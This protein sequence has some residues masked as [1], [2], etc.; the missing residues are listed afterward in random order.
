MNHLV[1]LLMIL[2]IASPAISG[3]LYIWTDANGRKQITDTPPVD[4]KGKV[5]KDSFRRDDP[6]EIEAWQRKNDAAIDAKIQEQERIQEQNAAKNKQALDA[7]VER[8]KAY[9]R[10]AETT[11][12]REK[13]ATE[14][15]NDLKAEKELLQAIENRDYNEVRR[16]RLRDEQRKIDRDIND[17]KEVLNKNPWP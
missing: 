3:E 17:N 15:I 14:R 6:Q 10:R 1:I 5:E 9:R 16:L 12:I 13:E 2:L 8:S 7:S 4:A 11:R